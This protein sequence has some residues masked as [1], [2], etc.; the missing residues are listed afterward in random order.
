MHA[1]RSTDGP[2]AARRG[3]GDARLTLLWFVEWLGDA[4]A[5]PARCSIGLPRR[6]RLWFISA[7]LFVTGSLIPAGSARA[8]VAALPAVG[9]SAD[10]GI[11]GPSVTGL[12]AGPSNVLYVS[13]DYERLAMRSGRSVRFDGSGARRT[14]WP[15]V[16][17]P[18]HTVV[19]DGAGGW[20]IGGEFAHVAGQPR[21]GLAH[22]GVGGELD[23]VWVPAVEGLD[24]DD[25]LSFT[26][27]LTVDVSALCVVG[28]TVY[29]SGAFTAIDGQPRDGLAAVD[30]VSGRLLPWNPRPRWGRPDGAHGGAVH[31][32]AAAGDTIYVGGAFTRMGSVVRRGLA[33]F[34][35]ATGALTAWNPAVSL[36]T[37][38]GVRALVIDRGTLYVGG[39]FEA[40][41]GQKRSGLAAFDVATGTLTAWNPRAVE[42]V[43]VDVWAL[44]VA[45]DTVYVGGDFDGM[46]RAERLSLAA[47]DAHTGRLLPWRADL[48]RVDDNGVAIALAV[49]GGRL[50]VGGS[51]DSIAGQPRTNLAAFSTTTG[52]LSPWDPRPSREVFSLVAAGDGIIAGGAFSGVDSVRRSGIAAID[53]DTGALLPFDA[54]AS[55]TT[56]IDATD[57]DAIATYGSSVFVAGGLGRVG[58]RRRLAVS[59]LDTQTGRARSWNA[60]VESSGASCC[61]VTAL[62]VYGRRLYVGGLLTRIGGQRRVHLAAVDAR[63]GRVT[64]WRMDANDWVTGLSVH[65]RTLYV[66]GLFTRIGGQR[67]RG[68]AA[69]DLRSGRLT[70][71]NPRPDG[72]VETLAFT[73]G[74]VYLGG[75]FR[76]V[77]GPRRSHLAAVNASDGKVQAWRADANASVQA[78]VV[79]AGTVYAGGDFTSIAGAPRERIAALDTRSGLPTAWNPGADQ[80]V[81]ALLATPAGL[82]AAGSFTSLGGT[83]QTG[84]GVFPPAAQTARS[85]SH[86]P[87][88]QAAGTHC[89]GLDSTEVGTSAAA[90]ASNLWTGVYFD[91]NREFDGDRTSRLHGF[92]RLSA[93]EGARAFR[94]GAQAV[95]AGR[96]MAVSMRRAAASI[97]AANWLTAS[98]APCSPQPAM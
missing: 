30:G 41:S 37:V 44:A 31:A 17:G 34:D 25:R 38:V 82:V 47:V 90:N 39:L 63:T 27:N 12:A 71:W 3:I 55:V 84:V 87:L 23:P 43:T 15:E 91:G 65:G 4:L 89:F 93:R 13:G 75:E 21:A 96:Q 94:N 64:P 19:A 54:H 88:P 70:A 7:L 14:A 92:T 53:H 80:Q 59:K 18:V 24:D 42:F 48:K 58:G 57:I 46:G 78:L 95:A 33:A 49:A 26:A 79:I 61:G 36:E 1:G 68:I 52:T 6:W 76:R 32:L 5:T 74:R 9:L 50:Y 16:D 35:A 97:V 66:T 51:F 28:D 2:S 73:R 62:A 60:R 45:G 11:G 72:K 29:V 77:G 85:A 22:I 40:I 83:S 81:A 56:D 69:V 67:R 86:R 8:Q 20:F 98:S 10:G